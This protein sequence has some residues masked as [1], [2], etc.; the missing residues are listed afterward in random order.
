MQI[1]TDPAMD[2]TNEQAQGLNLHSIPL[3]ITLNGK[4]YR[5]GV[6]IQPEQF[7]ELLANTDNF[8]TTSMPSSGEFAEKYREM[9]KTDPEILSIHISS[10]LSGTLNAARL[11]VQLVPEAK[12]TLIDTKTLSCPM[13]WQVQA[14]A[15]AL[16]KKWDISRIK[17][18]L[19]KINLHT[20]AMFTLPTLK[21][22]IHGGRISHIK[23]LLGSILNIKPII[24]VEKDRGTYVQ[25]G[26]DMTLK[27]SILKIIDRISRLFPPSTH[28]RV[29]PLHAINPEGVQFLMD[30]LNKRFKVFWEAATP[31]APVLGAHTGPGLVGCAVGNMEDFKP[32]L[33]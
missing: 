14:A 2:L 19:S 17:E 22:L 33:A 21:Y 24:G 9:A 29:Q 32:V 10:G 20:E 6:D 1:L 30:E 28:L 12:V 8:P 13:G 26:Q 25:L 5:S 18:L 11:G 27:K 23:G 31:I 3:R 16:K 7:Y 4:T 15:L